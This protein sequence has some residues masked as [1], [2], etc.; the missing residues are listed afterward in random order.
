MRIARITAV[1]GCAV[2]IGLASLGLGQAAEPIDFKGKTIE[3][4]VASSPGGGWDTGARS[5]A[6]TLQKILPGKPRVLVRNVPGGGG[7]RA[8]R[9]LGDRRTPRDGTVIS[10]VHGR[11]FLNDILE[12]PHPSYDPDKQFIAALRSRQTGHPLWVWRDVATSWDQIMGMKCC[13]TFPAGERGGGSAIEAGPY[14]AAMSGAPIKMIWGYAPGTRDR[15]AAFFRHETQLY[16]G[17]IVLRYFPELIQKRKI[18]P[19]LWWGKLA[20]LDFEDWAGLLKAGGITTNPPHLFDALKV[21]KSM[22][23]AF[24]VATEAVAIHRGSYVVPPGTPEHIRQFWAKT[25]A[26]VPKDPAWKKRL[27]AAGISPTDIGYTSREQVL[28]MR[29]TVL[30]LGPDE[31]K[32]FLE[33]VFGKK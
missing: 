16:G 33:L 10:P 1:L 23:V 19:V 14:L 24:T 2:I 20:P 21:P 7:D 29:K 12:K 6:L 3:I 17:M 25:L 18:V 26:Q 27:L 9:R 13:L 31:K 22:Q 8:L 4:I 15:A 11:W 5:T 28:A 30:G 32:M